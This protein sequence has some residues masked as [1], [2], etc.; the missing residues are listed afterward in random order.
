MIVR[1]RARARYVWLGAGL[2][3]VGLVAGVALWA[4]AGSQ[5]QI[6][7]TPDKKIVHG[8][9]YQVFDGSYMTF[10]YPSTYRVHKL[11]AKDTDLEL[12]MLTADTNYDKRLAVSVSKLTAGGLND[13]S[14]YLL[15]QSQP[16]TYASHK[17]SVDG[18]PALVWAKKDGLEQTVFISHGDKVAT[19]AFTTT[20]NLDDLQPQVD[21]LLQTFRWKV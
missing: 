5:G 2:L 20:G 16:D 14:A 13:N 6:V 4:S 9:A 15:R 3:V 8:P 21:A 7:V 10:S 11:D 17:V 12:F 18:S 19:L 1:R